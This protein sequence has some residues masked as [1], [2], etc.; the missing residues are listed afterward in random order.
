MPGWQARSHLTPSRHFH[1]PL[2]EAPSSHFLIPWDGQLNGNSLSLFLRPRFTTKLEGIADTH[3]LFLSFYERGRCTREEPC[4]GQT[5]VGDRIGFGPKSSG[6][7]AQVSFL[8]PL[9]SLLLYLLLSYSLN[10]TLQPL[11]GGVPPPQNYFVA[12]S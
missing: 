8:L 11:C 4:Q 10:L 7:P 5:V 2:G 6:S 12:T 3:N 9:T 1:L